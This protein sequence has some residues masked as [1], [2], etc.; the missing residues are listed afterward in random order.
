MCGWFSLP[1]SAASLRNM[2]LYIAASSSPFR[3]SGN[4]TL[5]ATWRLANGSSA[6]YT[7]PV[8]PLPSSR[9]SW[10]LPTD[11]IVAMDARYPCLVFMGS[12]Y[13]G[14]ERGALDF[15]HETRKS[16]APRPAPLGPLEKPRYL[17]VV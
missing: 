8:A 12:D 15:R 16:K 11:C 10:Y 6:R 13:K 2:F 5:M 17:P 9:I 7:L 14:T 3:A 4:A 1:A